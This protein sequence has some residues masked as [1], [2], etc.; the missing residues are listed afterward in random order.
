MANI[1]FGDAQYRRS[2]SGHS[3]A[4]VGQLPISTTTSL[5]RHRGYLFDTTAPAVPVRIRLSYTSFD[6]SAPRLSAQSIKPNGSVDVSIDVKNT[7][8][9][10]ATRLVQLYIHDR[11]SR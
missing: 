2:S 5:A 6:V 9:A 11:F 7:G 3:R 4:F 10:Q 1:L 8:A